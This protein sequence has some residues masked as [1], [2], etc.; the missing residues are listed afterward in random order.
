MGPDNWHNLKSEWRVAGTGKRQSPIDITTR[1]AMNGMAVKSPLRRPVVTNYSSSRITLINNGHTIQANFSKDDNNTITLGGE[2]LPD[3][4]WQG[5]EPY[6]LI[7]FHFH[8]RSEHKIDNVD[9]PMEMHLVHAQVANPSKLAV[10]GVM[11]KE[12]AENVHIKKFW[13][14]LPTPP[15]DHG[16]EEGQEHKLEYEFDPKTLIPVGGDYFQYQGSLTTPPC[17][18]NVCWTVIKKPITFSKKQIKAFSTMFPK[19][20]RNVQKAF[21]RLI[22]RYSNSDN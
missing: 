3:G 14:H 22:L 4:S 8:H 17:S 16:K 15:A 2:S 18:E 6:K 10:I 7:Q 13:E 5:G 9:Y 12:G 1:N 21:D 20:N 19:N 11:I